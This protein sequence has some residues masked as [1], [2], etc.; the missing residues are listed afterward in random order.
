M[1]RRCERIMNENI[2]NFIGREGF[3]WWIGQV[4]NDGAKFW[5]AE[6]EDGLVTLTMVTGTGLIK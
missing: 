2:A 6:L 4:E 5:N 3:N 1:V